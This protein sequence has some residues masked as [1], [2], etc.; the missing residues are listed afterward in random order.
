ME[1]V[2]TNMNIG[3]KSKQRI[4]NAEKGFKIILHVFPLARRPL[5]TSLSAE[6]LMM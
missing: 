1:Y 3:C 5:D 4:D 2:N 6:A